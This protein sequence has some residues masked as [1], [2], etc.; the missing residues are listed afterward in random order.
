MKMINISFQ[1]RKTDK[2][3][4]LFAASQRTVPARWPGLA[5]H[6]ESHAPRR[7]QR[8]KTSPS[9]ID[10]IAKHNFISACIPPRVIPLRGRSTE[11]P[12]PIFRSDLRDLKMRA[13][14]RIFPSQ[15]DTR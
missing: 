15:S 8:E 6:F 11:G 9:R 7:A 5:L 10:L 3:N 13:A 14:A 2:S 12:E 1:I 4:L